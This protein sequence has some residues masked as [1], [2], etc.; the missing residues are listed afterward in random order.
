MDNWLLNMSGLLP[1]IRNCAKLQ[2]GVGEEVPRIVTD[3]DLDPSVVQTVLV[4]HRNLS[5]IEMATD[6]NERELLA[7]VHLLTT[8]LRYLQGAKL[9]IHF[10][11]MNAATVCEKGSGKFRL[12]R[13]AT[14]IA[15][16]CEQNGTV[17]RP[18]W[19]PRCLNNVA[20]FISKMVDYEDYS[21]SHDFFHL[22]QQITGFVPDFD[23]FANN[24]NTKCDQFNSATFCVG[25]VGVNAYNYH[26]GH[27]AKNWLFPPPRLVAQTVRYLQSCNGV[28]LLITPQWKSS[29]FYPLLM[30]FE[31]THVLKGKWAFH[32]RNIFCKGADASSC[33]GPEF[34][35]TVELRLLDFNH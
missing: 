13:Y 2:I 8:C 24:M 1:R 15:D 28:G 23:R 30:S 31:N 12:Q 4:V 20:D 32:G 29:S 34:T 14:Y 5:C 10:D 7:A 21:V 25:S 26:W 16:L 22:A 33:F 6:S 17:I 18:V 9:T 19:I 3:H 11:N 27:G 35:G